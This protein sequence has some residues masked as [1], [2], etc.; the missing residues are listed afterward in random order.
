MVK[1]V[2]NGLHFFTADSPHYFAGHLDTNVGMSHL[3]VTF[4]SVGKGKT[5][6]SAPMTCL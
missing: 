2:L 4:P 1:C 3:E 5:K 6:T